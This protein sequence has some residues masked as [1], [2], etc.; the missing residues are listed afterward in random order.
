MPKEIKKYQCELCG[1][2]YDSKQLA[3]ECEHVHLH[4]VSI[5]RELFTGAFRA[6]AIIHVK[7]GDGSIR[8]YKM[9]GVK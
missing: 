1:S 9:D 8:A 7:L 6:P 4:A 5:E 3:I 2:L